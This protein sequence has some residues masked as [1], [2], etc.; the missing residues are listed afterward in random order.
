MSTSGGSSLSGRQAEAARNDQRILEAARRVFI[1][2]PAAPI[3][4]VADRAGVGISALYRRYRS[5]DDLLRRLCGDG[6]QVYI[7]AAE[8]ALAS[9]DDPW[10]AFVEFM[11]RVVEADTHA[12]ATHVAG[13]FAPTDDLYREAGRASRLTADLLARVKARRLIRAD[14]EAADLSLLFELLAAVRLR[15][16]DR[17]RQ[18]RE[19]N[20]ALM[21]AALQ[22]VEAPP[23]PGPAPT[24]DEISGR[25]DV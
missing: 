15:D 25:W 8:R 7:A 6:L 12:L 4:A 5:K 3:A 14:I 16:E 21:L 23:L 24:W 20:L 22:M 2:D 18:V 9:E 17:T 11:R 13:T 1:A 10:A 19:R